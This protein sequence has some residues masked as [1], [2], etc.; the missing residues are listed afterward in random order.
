M[1]ISK[2]YGTA[3]DFFHTVNIMSFITFTILITLFVT[4]LR[5]FFQKREIPPLVGSEGIWYN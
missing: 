3:L 5:N 2:N 1:T 4:Y